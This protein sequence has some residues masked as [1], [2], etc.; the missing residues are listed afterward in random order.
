MS[1]LNTLFWLRY[2]VF[3]NSF[4]TRADV[5]RRLLNVILLLI[6]MLM[7]VG[8]GIGLFVVLLQVEQFRGPVVSGGM[9]TVLAT[10]LFLMLISQSTGASS[11]FDPRR[12]VLF[13]IRLSKLYALNLLSALGEFS[14]LMVLPAMAGMLLGLGFAYQQPLGGVLAFV[15]ALLWVDALFVCMGMLFAWLLSGRKRS[16]EILFALLIGGM[17]IGGQLLPRFFMTRY[18]HGM[19]QWILPYKNILS[20]IFDWTPIGVWSYFF[21][22]LAAHETTSAYLHLLVVCG[23]WIS[24]ALAVGYTLFLRLTT[25]ASSSSSAVPRQNDLGQIQSHNVLAFHLPFVSGQVSAVVA[26]ELRYLTRNPA[27]YLTILSSLVF[28][29]IFLR[30]GRGIGDGVGW[31]SG[32]VCYVFLMNFQYFVGLFAYDAAGFR[33][34]LMSPLK[35]SRLLLGKNIAIWLIVTVQISLVLL[36]AEFLDHNL[37]IEK[38]FVA[39]CS[40]LISAALFSTAGNYISIYFPYRV[41]FGV[42]A[43][44]RENWSGINLLM[45]FGLL[46]GVIALLLLPIGFGYW[47]KS[48]NLMYAIFILLALASW[49]TYVWCL[50]RQ[51]TLLEE[52]RFEVAETLTRKTEKV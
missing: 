14:M 16:R 30:S 5:A 1:Q 22:H 15:L 34:Y 26:K 38:I 6:P 27:T 24:L 23:L 42:P 37:T 10:L 35:W 18:G 7:S 29:L 13:P 49:G 46:F 17:T 45:Q 33:Q 48:K 11:H 8:I 40:S 36:G 19:V 28:P 39:G 25:S 2:T 52:R 41:Q 4:S 20:T 44:R 12:F 43:R 9:T 47:L 3:K 51:G 50:E 21:R 31:V 32:W